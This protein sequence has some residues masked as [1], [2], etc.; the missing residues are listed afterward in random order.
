MSV[1][2]QSSLRF[3]ELVAKSERLRVRS[4]PFD[5]LHELS[6]L[7]REHSA[8]LARL[9]DRD[10]DPDAIRHL[11]A[12]CVRAYAFLYAD[13]DRKGRDRGPWSRQLAALLA[14]TWRA[15]A[16]AWLLLALGAGLGA[17][18]AAK[19]PN[20]VYVLLPGA[21]GYSPERIDA[22]RSSADE[23]ANFL[24]SKETPPSTNLAFGSWLFTHNS[25]VGLLAFATGMFAGIPTALLQLYNGM[26]LGAFASVFLVDPWPIDFLAWL[27]PHAIPELSAVTLCCAAGFML[28]AGVAM[29]GRK[30]R[31]DA[32]RDNAGP[33]LLLFCA[34]LPLFAI[35]AATE[36]FL[37]ESALASAPRLLVATLYLVALAGA[38]FATR[39]LARREGVDTA[40]IGE[41]APLAESPTRSGGGR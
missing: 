29:P 39:A 3:E 32:I 34:A 14:R 41:V 15:H 7:Y 10:A 26:M 4:M 2:A 5:D 33:A 13:S 11:N 36:S 37:R 31:R 35:A 30:R 28:G 19:D 20:A 9:R 17:G 12:L 18:L 6:R 23:R 8:R 40:W 25:E 21:F 22:L 24:R 1:E 38:L 16:L 27:L